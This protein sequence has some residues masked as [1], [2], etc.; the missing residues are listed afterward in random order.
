[1]EVKDAIYQRRSVRVYQDK[2]IEKEV[3]EEI[4]QAGVWAPTSSNIQAW[5]FVC[6]TDP[7]NI[8]TVQTLS[9][10]MFA[11]AKANIIICC[12]YKK[13]KAKFG[14]KGEIF[15]IFDCAVASENM[16]LRAHDLGVGTCLIRSFSQSGLREY[17]NLPDHIVPELVIAAGYPSGQTRS[18]GRKENKI[19]WEKYGGSE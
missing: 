15:G 19:H 18:P 3:L 5:V 9:P 13:I 10:G 16:M 11:H 12:D 17:L 2:P 1:M 14:E 6:I 4:V 7:Q 8:K